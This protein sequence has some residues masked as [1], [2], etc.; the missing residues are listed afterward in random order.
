MLR[1][2]VWWKFLLVCLSCFLVSP[3]WVTGVAADPAADKVDTTLWYFWRES[4]P[5]CQQANVWLTDLQQR[6]PHLHIQKFEVQID[7][8]ARERFIEMMSDRGMQAR[9]VPTFII[10]NQVWQG[11]SPDIAEEIE[12]TLVSGQTPSSDLVLSL[13]PF[14]KI[15]LAEQSLLVATI[16]IAFVDGFNPCSLWVLTVLL[17]MVLGTRSRLRLAA[18]GITFLL[19]TSAI[20]GLFIS[21]L[22]A[23]FTF[24]AHLA[25]IQVFV[26]LLA[27]LFGLVNV[28]DFFAFKKGLSFTI[29]ERFKPAIYR[30]GRSLRAERPL[31]ATLLIAAGLAGGVAIIEL[32][33][34]AG[35][36][37]VWSN[38]VA[39]A[40]IG[41]GPFFLLLGV[42]LLI[43]LIDE[44]AIV[45]VAVVTMRATRMQERS[46][47]LLKLIGGM[48]MTVLG[49]VMLVNRS[50]LESLNGLLLIFLLAGVGAAA[51]LVVERIYLR[52][53][54]QD[55]QG[56]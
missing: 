36:P 32:P 48:I 33:C 21:G 3:F 7:A 10:D 26:G 49:V 55:D 28:K 6:H 12:L 14:G 30:G 54:T 19:I 16:L 1:L 31:A 15:E 50:L 34:T 53:C 17:A 43:Y 45:M 9:S 42:Y 2:N 44:I 47:R 56:Q 35:F 24:A 18:I 8:S 13:G 29:P 4:C 39:Q 38:L 20:Y 27:L 23:T 41:S 5:Y 46:G 25:W 40:N 37:M 11:Y 22:F 51:M 52:R